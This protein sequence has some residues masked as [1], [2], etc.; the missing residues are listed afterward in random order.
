M[1]ADRHR[2]KRQRVCLRTESGLR[3][4]FLS[5]KANLWRLENNLVMAVGGCWEWVSGGEGLRGD[6]VVGGGAGRVL[7]VSLWWKHAWHFI[8][9]QLMWSGLQDVNPLPAFWCLVSTV[10][11]SKF[12]QR[13]LLHR[14]PEL[15]HSRSDGRN[16]SCSW[17]RYFPASTSP[18]CNTV[19]QC[20]RPAARSAE[21]HGDLKISPSRAR[22]IISW[23]S[24]PHFL[25]HLPNLSYTIDNTATSK[26][27]QCC[28]GDRGHMR[29]WVTDLSTNQDHWIASYHDAL[30]S[31]EN[32]ESIVSRRSLNHS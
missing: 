11:Q 16:Q 6:G 21:P 9:F 7:T 15:N 23:K 30:Q 5:G 3:C 27:L 32:V 22:Y 10:A 8:P 26:H 19:R 31:L 1:V 13:F 20:D 28:L 12:L 18:E 4:R 29:G 14:R 25:D 17:G 2:E 24:K